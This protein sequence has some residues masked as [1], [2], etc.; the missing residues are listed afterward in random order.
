MYIIILLLFYFLVSQLPNKLDAFISTGYHT[1]KNSVFQKPRKQT[2]VSCTHFFDVHKT[3][4]NVEA[5][6]CIISRKI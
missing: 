2:Y 5:E 4:W 3:T 1:L 6:S